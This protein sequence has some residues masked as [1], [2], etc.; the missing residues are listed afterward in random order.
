MEANKPTLP[1]IR[2]GRNLLIA[3]FVVVAYVLSWNTTQ[4]DIPRLFTDAPK[5]VPIITDFVTPDV[6]SRA[7]QVES[8]VINYPV[9][10][11]AGEAASMPDTG[12]R[13]VPNPSC[14]DVQAF[15]TVAGFELRP[16]TGVQMR[17]LLPDGRRLRAVK[18]TTD[19]QGHFSAEVEIRPIVAAQE[20]IVSQLQAELTWES[21]SLLPSE[22]FK[23]TLAKIVETV[24]MALMATTFACLVAFPASFL[25]ARNVMGSGPVGSAVYYLFRTIFNLMRSIEALVIAVMFAIWL[26]FGPFA[27]VMAM[28]VVTIA[29]LGKLFSEAIESIDEGTIEA[30]TATGANRLQAVAYAVLPQI[31]PPFIAFAIYHWDINVRISTIIGFVGGGGIGLQLQTWINEL[32][33]HKAGTAVW[34]IVVVVTVLDNVSSE[35]RKRLV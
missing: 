18:A 4:I 9:P 33:Y 5:A 10:C 26:G 20:G 31:V 30:I 25:G 22:A 1:A 23:T 35:I 6:F 13:L 2:Y 8:H 12:P 24:F 27:G 28:I 11:G 34:A 3:I 16:N 15:I 14:A 17:W 21:G 7:E 29:S 32:S 19:D